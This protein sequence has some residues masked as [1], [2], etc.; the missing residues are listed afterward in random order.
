MLKYRKK[1]EISSNFPSDPFF[2]WAEIVHNMKATLTVAFSPAVVKLSFDFPTS[3]I[4]LHPSDKI[5]FLYSHVTCVSLIFCLDLNPLN[6][7]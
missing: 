1:N 5:P 4:L 7:W 2:V 3:S 6:R